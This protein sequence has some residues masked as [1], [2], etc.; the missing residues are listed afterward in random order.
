MT[1]TKRKR[2]MCMGIS[3]LTLQARIIGAKPKLTLMAKTRVIVMDP[4]Y[5]AVNGSRGPEIRCCAYT[6]GPI[7]TAQ[8][9]KNS[10]EPID[11]LKQRE[12]SVSYSSY[13]MLGT[14]VWN[15]AICSQ[16]SC[17]IGCDLPMLEPQPVALGS[18]VW[19]CGQ[20]S[21]RCAWRRS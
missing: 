12:A 20:G 17:L 19:I 9:A 16:Q 7:K 13:A 5:A 8:D 4:K 21:K 3:G 14:W 18:S 2:G 1:R 11:H 15:Q 10:I 6:R